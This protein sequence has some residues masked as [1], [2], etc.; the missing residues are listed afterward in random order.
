MENLS[1]FALKKEA[2]NSLRG[3]TVINECY[4]AGSDYIFTFEDR[5]W[6]YIENAMNHYCGGPKSSF[7]CEMSIVE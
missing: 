5:S 7:G 4:C 2:M 3:G 1:K 6:E